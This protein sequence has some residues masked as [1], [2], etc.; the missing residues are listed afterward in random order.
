[1]QILFK[2]GR[3]L[4]AEGTGL[5]VCGPSK[6]PAEMAWLGVDSSSLE[7]ISLC[8]YVHTIGDSMLLLKPPP[9]LAEDRPQNVA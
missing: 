1:M 5:L 3:F 2:K 4:Q 9:D 7:C 6:L 8:I